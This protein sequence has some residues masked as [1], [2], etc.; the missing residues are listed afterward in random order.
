MLHN[1][2]YYAQVD[3]AP[4]HEVC[5]DDFYMDKYEV[6]QSRWEKRMKFNPSKFTGSD[7]P[8]EQINYYDVQEIYL[9]NWKG[10]ATCPQKR[11]GN[12]L[13]EDGPR[14]VTSG[15]I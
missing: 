3:E 4:E 10:N 9:A 6:T 15:A 2:K 8:V 13:L 5:L 14:R 1:G 11:N 7:L 12:T